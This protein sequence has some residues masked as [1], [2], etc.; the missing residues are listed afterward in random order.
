MRNKLYLFWKVGKIL[1]NKNNS[2]ENIVNRYS[3]LLSYYFG[4][5]DTFSIVN[6]NYMKKFYKSFPIYYKKLD[7]LEFEHYKL[8]VN[9]SDLKE[10]YFYFRIAL[11]CQ[12]SVDELRQ[13]I[14]SNT[15]LFI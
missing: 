7:E 14:M 6:V 13:I 8:L 10:R 9:I 5:S 15:Y 12:S 4:M 3:K 11:F 2:C 1:I